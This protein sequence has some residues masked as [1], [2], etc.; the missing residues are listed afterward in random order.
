M[1]NQGGDPLVYGKARRK[2]TNREMGGKGLKKV[3]NGS[4]HWR[5]DNFLDPVTLYVSPLFPRIQSNEKSSATSIPMKTAIFYSR[6]KN[7]SFW[8]EFNKWCNSTN[9]APCILCCWNNGRRWFKFEFL[10]HFATSS[11]VH[12]LIGFNWVA[13]VACGAGGCRTGGCWGA[14][15]GSAGED[16]WEGGEGVREGDWGEMGRIPTLV[17]SLTN[18]FILSSQFVSSMN[19]NHI[20]FPSNPQPERWY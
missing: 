16:A 18:A 17:S 14:A 20:L 3:F 10:N 12:F 7:A 9:E 1:E 11:G 13:G 4:L 19:E 2:R 15:R 5:K 6:G 8:F